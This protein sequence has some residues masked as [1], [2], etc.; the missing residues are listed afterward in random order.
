MARIG[1]LID[2][3]EEASLDPAIKPMYLSSTYNNI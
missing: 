3:A 1:Y 2:S